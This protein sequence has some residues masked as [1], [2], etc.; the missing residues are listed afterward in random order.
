MRIEKDIKEKTLINLIYVKN[1]IKLFLIDQLTKNLANKKNNINYVYSHM[2]LI[3]Q[4]ES[5][6]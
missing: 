3:P 1:W 5:V 6:M 2:L 4:N